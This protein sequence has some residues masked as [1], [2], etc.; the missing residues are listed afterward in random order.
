MQAC[1]VPN[2]PPHDIRNF[3]ATCSIPFSTFRPVQCPFSTSVKCRQ[4][5]HTQQHS[6]N[7]PPKKYIQC[8]R[9]TNYQPLR[10]Y[11]PADP[12]PS[13]TMMIFTLSLIPCL[14][15]FVLIACSIRT[16]APLTENLSTAP[17]VQ[18]VVPFRHSFFCNKV[19]SGIWDFAWQ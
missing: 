9:Y 11:L 16:S 19:S 1:P 10:Q 6:V 18:R 15:I 3:S 14:G 2:C 5:L 4:R 12:V 13:I 7:T 8:R 17:T